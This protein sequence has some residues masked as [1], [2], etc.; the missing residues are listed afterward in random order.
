MNGLVYEMASQAAA[1]MSTELPN[2]TTEVMRVQGTG[3]Y[4]IYASIKRGSRH[5]DIIIN[6]PMELA[7]ILASIEKQSGKDL[8]SGIKVE[9]ERSYEPWVET[10]SA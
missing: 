9:Q 6:N 10:V 1:A 4:V 5:K 7:L 3:R 8:S 2:V